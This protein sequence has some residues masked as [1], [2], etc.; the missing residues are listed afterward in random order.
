MNGMFR[1]HRSP[2]GRTDLGSEPADGL[3]RQ[4]V[5]AQSDLDFCKKMR[6]FPNSFVGSPT[7]IRPMEVRQRRAP[8]N[9]EAVF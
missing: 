1:V 6:E 8:D 4:L 3:G 2:A 7:V 9:H 5:L